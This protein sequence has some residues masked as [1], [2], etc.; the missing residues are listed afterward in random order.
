MLGLTEILNAAK[1]ELGDRILQKPIKCSCPTCGKFV[2]TVF[3]V[4]NLVRNRCLKCG[5]DVITLLSKEGEA[6]AVTER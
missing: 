3:V 5:V 1:R 4:P 6:L 2:T